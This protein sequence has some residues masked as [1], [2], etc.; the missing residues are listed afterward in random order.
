MARV[1]DLAVVRT[2]NVSPFELCID[3]LCHDRASY[4]RLLEELSVA[5]VAVLYGVAE[6]DCELSTSAPALAIK[7]TIPREVDAGGVGDW[8][9]FGAAQAVPLQELPL[10]TES[11]PMDTPI[12]LFEYEE[13]ARELLPRKEYDFIA[14]GA[15]DEITVRRARAVFDSILLRQRVLRDVASR[16]LSTTVLGRRVDCPIMV[17]PA[18]FH[19]RVT[20]DGELAT[21]RAAHAMGTIIVLSNSSSHTLEDVGAA[22]PGGKWFQ[23][24]LY[25]DRDLTLTMAKRAE[26]AGYDAVCITLD[27]PPVPPKRERSIHNRYSQEPSPNYAGLGV[28]RYDY[29]RGHDAM[30]G[31]GELIDHSATWDDLHWF[32]ENAGLP[33]VVKGILAGEDGALAVS[34][35]ASGIVVSAH[36]GR[37]LDTTVTS[38]EALPEVVAAVDGRAEVYLDSGIRRGTDVFK[39]LALGARA[40]LF[41]RPLFWGLAVG[42][43]AGL[44]N[45]IQILKD[46]L[47]LTMAL[48]GHSTLGTIG[49]DSL[50]LASPLV[51]SLPATPAPTSVSGAQRF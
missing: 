38:I 27:F 19:T 14:Q 43:E 21:A 28:P 51:P 7:F 41:G 50:Y 10:R 3:V 26:D 37:Q 48:C 30:R 13:R 4:E 5:V 11:S 42:G 31:V 17:C 35:G 8:D 16:D 24:Y 29:G 15:T 1:G 40:V 22:T 34:A 32:A 6:A 2:K 25:K 20:P 9:I 49:P 46:E 39:A 18:G 36:G 12:N 44:R 33:V 23:H 47:E 45:V